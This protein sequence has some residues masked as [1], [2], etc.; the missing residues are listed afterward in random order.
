MID[1]N[2]FD[3]F[4]DVAAAERLTNRIFYSTPSLFHTLDRR[5]TVEVSCSLALKNSPMVDHG[6]EAPDYVLGRYMFH[7]PLEVS[8]SL[9]PQIISFHSHGIGTQQLQGPKDRIC[10]HHLQPQQKLLTLRLKLWL[11]V[12]SYDETRKKWGMR[13]IVCPVLGPD[14]WH[15]RLHFTHK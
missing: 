13:T 9:L 14:Y 8:T 6:E 11:R 5:V 7:K 10:Y 1:Q 15:I 12:R 3:A 2:G 4:A